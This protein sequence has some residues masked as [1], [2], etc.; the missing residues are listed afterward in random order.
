MF[1]QG[2]EI[3]DE[4]RGVFTFVDLEQRSPCELAPQ[5]SSPQT[6]VLP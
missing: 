3:N 1:S 5:N 6:S 4:G 2:F